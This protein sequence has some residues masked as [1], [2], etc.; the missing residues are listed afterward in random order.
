MEQRKLDEFIQQTCTRIY[1]NGRTRYSQQYDSDD[2]PRWQPRNR[3]RANLMIKQ[4]RLFEIG[5]FG[6]PKPP[7]RPSGSP[8]KTERV[9][10]WHLPKKS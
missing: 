4:G 10:K 9:L 2:E 1:R 7:G 6:Q 3:I 5:G 8:N